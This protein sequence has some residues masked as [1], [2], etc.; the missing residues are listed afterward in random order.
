M[1]Y[2]FMVFQFGHILPH[3]EIEVGP[4]IFQHQYF[5]H[6]AERKTNLE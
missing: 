4:E 2:E 6:F 5:F 3:H 1:V